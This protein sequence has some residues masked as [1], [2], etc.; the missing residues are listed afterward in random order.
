MIVSYYVNLIIR[1]ISYPHTVM[2]PCCT[3]VKYHCEISWYFLVPCLPQSLQNYKEETKIK[4]SE[5]ALAMPGQ[6]SFLCISQNKFSITRVD[7]K[8]KCTRTAF[9]IYNFYHDHTSVILYPLLCQIQTAI[10]EWSKLTSHS[11]FLGKQHTS[12]SLGC[13]NISQDIQGSLGCH[14]QQLIKR[15]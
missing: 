14:M 6:K 2:K 7:L 5:I 15:Y 3:N 13:C 11:I 4:P 10:S 9:I 8:N 12:W 1:L